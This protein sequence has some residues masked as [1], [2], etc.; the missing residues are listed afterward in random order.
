MYHPDHITSGSKNV[1]P[2]LSLLKPTFRA[3]AILKQK[4]F[5]KFHELQISQN[6]TAS[7]W[8]ECLRSPQR[9]AFGHTAIACLNSRVQV[10]QSCGT[11]GDKLVSYS[12]NWSLQRGATVI[13]SNVT[14]LSMSELNSRRCSGDITSGMLLGRHC[15]IYLSV[16]LANDFCCAVNILFTVI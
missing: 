7:S 12:Y 13:E 10:N 16:S 2:W 15:Y 6:N 14:S 11:I 4:L 9:S 1:D 3:N 5:R 8:P